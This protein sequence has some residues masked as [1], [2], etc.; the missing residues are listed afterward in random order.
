MS[1]QQ[2]NAQRAEWSA[3]VIPDAQKKAK[4]TVYSHFR[5]VGGQE[6]PNIPLFFRD[7][8][9]EYMREKRKN[10]MLG[11]L[12]ATVVALIGANVLYIRYSGSL[13]CNLETPFR[14]LHSDSLLAD[15]K[16]AS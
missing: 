12:T 11:V 16:P 14:K 2:R 8:E 4:T 6:E 3:D 9:E 13:F 1:T 5:S 10:R 7:P 15:S